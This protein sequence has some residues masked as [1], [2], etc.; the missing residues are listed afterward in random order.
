MKSKPS[1]FLASLTPY[2][3]FFSS[4]IK[5]KYN[6]LQ[7][8]YREREAEALRLTRE[9]DILAKEKASLAAD[10]ALASSLLADLREKRQGQA[11]VCIIY[12]V[13]VVHRASLGIWI[14]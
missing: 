8:R 7:V 9:V 1:A 6:A 14:Q 13:R 3:T 10:S 2:Q 12:Y 11:N 5:A 4:D